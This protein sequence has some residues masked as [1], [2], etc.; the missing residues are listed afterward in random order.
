DR[1]LPIVQALMKKLPVLNRQDSDLHALRRRII[2][3]DGSIFTVPADVAWAIATTRRGGQDGKQIRLNLQLDVLHAMPTDFSISG[4]SDGSETAAF[5]RRLVENVIYIVD[6]GFV[7]F[8]FLHAVLDKNS[9]F[10]VRL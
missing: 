3:A 1:L 8:S 9:D 10:V 7:D 4:A 5:A 6:R 2:A